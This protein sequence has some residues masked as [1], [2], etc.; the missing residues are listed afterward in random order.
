MYGD[1]EVVRRRAA[2]LREQG[3]D[4]RALADRLV[5]RAEAIGWAGRAADSMR[6]RI[7]ER[8]AHLRVAA[9][10]HESAADLLDQ[11]GSA[12]EQG[13]E[14]IASVSRKAEQLF[15]DNAAPADFTPPP[16]GHKDW[17]DVTLPGL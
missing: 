11:H 4:I 6:A 17:L 15:A 2:Q 3:G 10:I 9:G 8:A 7:R 13:K 14:T 12:V 16:A 1:S 5:G